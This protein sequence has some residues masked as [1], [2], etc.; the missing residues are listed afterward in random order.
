MKRASDVFDGRLARARDRLDATAAGHVRRRATQFEMMNRALVLAGLSLML[1]VPALVAV[2][3]V[4][5]LGS[6]HTLAASWAR[7]MGLSGEAARAVRQLFAR[8]TAQG[9]TTLLSSLVTIA[10]AYSWPAEM[11]RGYQRIWSLPARGVR[12]AWRPVVWL[13]SFFAVIACV[14]SSGSVA[15][16][17]SGAAVVAVVGAP[18]VFGWT[19]WTQHLFLGGRTSYRRLVP[20]AVATTVGLAG[21]SV[22]MSFYL[23]SAI[24]ENYDKYGP[25]GVVFALLS[26]LIGFNVVMLGG[27]LAGH[28]WISRRE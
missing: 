27:P 21:L 8:N 18:V 20:G 9:T 28:V 6:D 11:Q 24:T 12:D 10:F 4:L 5:P 22:F 3:A 7:R 2:G 13:L 16:G 25:I 14:A 1:L 26:W 17:P 23:S 19:W 15:D